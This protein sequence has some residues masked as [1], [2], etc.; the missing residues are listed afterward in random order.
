MPGAAVGAVGVPVNEGDA[1]VALKAISAIFVVILDVLEVILASNPA[2]ALVAL[3][4]SAV[5]LDVFAA[6]ELVLAVILLASDHLRC[7]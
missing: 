2:S 3:V 1:I 5:M 7:R 6:I 4:I